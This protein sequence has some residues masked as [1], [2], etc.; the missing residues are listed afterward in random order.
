MSAVE[1]NSMISDKLEYKAMFGVCVACTRARAYV[2]L[3]D[4]ELASGD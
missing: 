4:D 3:G 2:Q 1:C